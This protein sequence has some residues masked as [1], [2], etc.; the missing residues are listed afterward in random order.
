[1]YLLSFVNGSSALSYFH[2]IINILRKERRWLSTKL[3]GRLMD[4][5][6]AKEWCADDVEQGYMGQQNNI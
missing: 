6:T 3:T 2:V 4:W 5:L 1:M